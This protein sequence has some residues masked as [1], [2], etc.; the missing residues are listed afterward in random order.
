MA[1]RAKVEQEA[2]REWRTANDRVNERLTAP[3]QKELALHVDKRWREAQVQAKPKPAE[4]APEM[5]VPSTPVECTA[6]ME[7]L[8]T[9]T[10]TKTVMTAVKKG[11]GDKGP[12]MN[13]QPVHKQVTTVQSTL[14]VEEAVKLGTQDWKPFGLDGHFTCIV[15]GRRCIVNKEVYAELCALSK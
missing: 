6:D 8:G 10:R 7:T 5:V 14:N 4:E 1:N 2:K 3:E 12:I 9:R 13:I 11:E 15:E